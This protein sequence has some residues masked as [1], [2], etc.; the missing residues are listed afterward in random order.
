MAH[1]L[2]DAGYRAGLAADDAPSAFEMSPYEQ[3]Y[4]LGFIAGFSEMQSFR[5]AS[6][7]VAGWQAG[8]LGRRY[9]IPLE[10]LLA[11]VKFE[12]DVSAE[13]RSEYEPDEEDE[14]PVP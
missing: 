10:V 5:H 13:V 2:F 12:T 6:I 11:R 9:G 7:P 1:S 14:D 8:E 3:E 4:V